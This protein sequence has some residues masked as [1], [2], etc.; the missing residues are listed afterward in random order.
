MAL[1]FVGSSLSD[2][3]PPPGGMS[4]KTAHFLAYAA[5]GAALIRALAAGRP[6]AMTVGRVLLAFAVATVYGIT[7]EFHQ[8]LVPNRMPDAMDLAA[9]AAGALAG[10]SALALLV[11][12]LS[13]LT[14]RQS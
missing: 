5:L 6:S 4:D 11:R 3:A 8:S 14:A 1:I 13:R 10:A 2:P 7:D 9:D 12:G